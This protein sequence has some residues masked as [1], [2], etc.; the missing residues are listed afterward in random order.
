MRSGVWNSLNYNSP[1]PP[2]VKTVH[3]FPLDIATRG[4]GQGRGE[5]PLP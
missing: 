3:G 5:T 1:L 2:V 4:W